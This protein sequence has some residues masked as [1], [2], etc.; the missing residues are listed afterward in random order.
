MKSF[1]HQTA[2]FPRV[3]NTLATIESMNAQ[4]LDVMDDGILGYE[5]AR[6]RHYTFRGI[7]YAIATHQQ[8]ETRV[9]QEQLKPNDDQGART[10]ARELRRTLQ[11]LG[12]VDNTGTVTPV[13]QQVLAS[14]AQSQTE[15]VLL[16]TGLLNITAI[17]KAGN[18]SHPVLMMLHLLHTAPSHRRLGLELALESENDSQAEINRV[19]Q[20]YTT[21]T[22][23]AQIRAATGVSE[24]QQRNNRKVLPAFS[25]YADL[26][27]EDAQHYFRLTPS[28]LRALGLPVSGQAAA[29]APAP[30]PSGAGA[31]QGRRTLTTGQQRTAGQ[32]GAHST[33]RTVP[34]AL[35][36]DQQAEAQNRLNERTTA[37]QDLVQ[38]F[39]AQIGDASGTLWEDRSSFDLVWGPTGAPEHHIFEM[40]TVQ[41]DADPQVIRAVGQLAYYRY[42]NVA[43][44]FPGAPTTRTLVVDDDLH[45]DLRDFLEAE[46]I[47]AIWMHADGTVEALN[48]LGQ[49]LVALL[50]TS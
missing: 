47:G 45:E 14:A 50:P 9:A 7:D 40:K 36:P 32:V 13:G 41:A 5:L 37:H 35:T 17:D 31:T 27:V 43:K 22:T 1:P 6:R 48:P 34:G 29:P 39:A 8:I 19:V 4:G 18:V 28:G 44:K 2:Q 12:W 24:S 11:G 26:V 10:N 42:F 21:N 49:A 23:D 16:A 33:N 3:R 25:K 20:I 38:L 46:G 30:T 15:R